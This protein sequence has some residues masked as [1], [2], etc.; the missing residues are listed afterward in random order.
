[1]WPAGI[2]AENLSNL[3]R[4]RS[5][6][7]ESLMSIKAETLVVGVETDLLFPIEE[8]VFLNKFIP[9]SSLYKLDSSYGHD[10]F[11]VEQKKVFQLIETFLDGRKLNSNPTILKLK[12]S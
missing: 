6:I 5:S 10:G 1:M 2:E 12:Y 9:N 4:D 11:L 3:G 7:E 8:Q